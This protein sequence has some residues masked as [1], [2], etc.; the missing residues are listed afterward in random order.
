[1]SPS[2]YKEAR[3]LVRRVCRLPHEEKREFKRKIARVRAHFERFNVD[4]SDLCQWLMSLRAKKEGEDRG[5]PVFWDFFLNPTIE[6]IQPDETVSDRWRLAVF[7]DVAG[8][9]PVFELAGRPVAD[10]LRQ[11]IREV[12]ERPKT[13][14]AE[15]LFERLHR[16]EPP[17]RLVLVK[18]AA[19]WI[20]ARYQHGIENWKRQ[21]EE[22]EKE[23]RE[24]EARHPQLTEPARIVFTDVFKNLIEDPEGDGAKG[25]R[26]KNPRICAYERL[27]Q[28]KDSC[29]YAGERGHDPLFGSLRAFRAS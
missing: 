9:A 19:E 16:L 3:T 4:V 2:R 14:T 20:A 22:W 11:A 1:V 12:A 27:S 15:R 10:S 24:W 21:R 25:L 6:G 13:P 26:R 8:I 29:V 5:V 28:N 17:H 23:K 18:A 7:D